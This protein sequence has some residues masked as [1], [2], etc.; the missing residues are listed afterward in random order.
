MLSLFNFTRLFSNQRLADSRKPILYCKKKTM[1]KL[2]VLF[3]VLMCTVAMS[4]R[5]NGDDISLSYKSSDRYYSMDAYYNKSSTKDVD[6]YLD[7]R[8]GKS[9][10][11][12]FAN[13]KLD[14][15]VTLDDHTT[16]YIKKTPGVLT[17]K[18]DKQENSE[19]AYQHVK[20]VCEGIKEVV[21]RQ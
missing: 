19:E 18:L 14:G 21:K 12:S 13:T 8:L 5:P 9:S 2:N 4:C 3:Y 10:N 17:I 1:K 15:T 20:S 11:M 7:N 16:F 6:E